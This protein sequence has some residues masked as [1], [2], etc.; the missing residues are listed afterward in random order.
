MKVPIDRCGDNIIAS[1]LYLSDGFGG[2]P[3]HM[4]VCN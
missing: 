2:W 4:F 3:E 1:L